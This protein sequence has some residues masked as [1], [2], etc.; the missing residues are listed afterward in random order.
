MN[1]GKG[2]LDRPAW[3]S[4]TGAKPRSAGIEN[5]G[6]HNLGSSNA[7][8]SK[9]SKNSSS[10]MPSYYSSTPRSARSNRSA[11]QP[12]LNSKGYRSERK[13]RSKDT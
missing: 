3:S 12:D 4:S 6:A 11:S 5:Y 2:D 9:H 7:G 13:P 10:W 8:T 1:Q